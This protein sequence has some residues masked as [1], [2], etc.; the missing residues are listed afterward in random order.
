MVDDQMPEG[1]NNFDLK[2]SFLNTSAQIL[3]IRK[4][5]T[6]TVIYVA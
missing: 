1:V 3:K 2:I 6:L 5:K 4:S